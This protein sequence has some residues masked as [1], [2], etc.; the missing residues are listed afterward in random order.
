[1]KNLWTKT[2][3]GLL[4]IITIFTL[5]GCEDDD[6]MTRSDI[7]G[8]WRIAEVQTFGGRCPYWEGDRLIFDYNGNFT[9]YGQNDF[10][11][12]GYWDVNRDVIQ[13]DFN[14][15]GRTDVIATIGSLDHGYLRLDVTDRLYGSEYTLRLTRW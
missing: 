12:Y 1:M 8:T 5:N 9:A 7:S 14:N 3:K 2:F 6:W 4:I 10:V 15:D 13:I 11:E